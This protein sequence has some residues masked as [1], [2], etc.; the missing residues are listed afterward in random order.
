MARL[1]PALLVALATI[2]LPALALTPVD[3]Q[4]LANAPDETDNWLS[5]G[6]DQQETRFSPLDE[7]AV[8]TLPRLVLEARQDHLLEAQAPLFGTANSTSVMISFSF[9]AVSNSPLKNLSASIVRLLVVI[10]AFNAKQ[11]AG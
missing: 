6:R 3:Q 4:R 5:H 2:A 11:A 1:L 10:F 9:S 8:D 7:I